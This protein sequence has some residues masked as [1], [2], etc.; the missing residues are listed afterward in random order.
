MGPKQ[1]DVDLDDS[2]ERHITTGERTASKRPFV[3]NLAGLQPFAWAALVDF[4]LQG[5]IHLKDCHV[6][7]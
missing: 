7:P 4:H 6:R 2:Y 3:G 1:L 5:S